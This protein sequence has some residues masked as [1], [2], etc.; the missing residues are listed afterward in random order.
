MEAPEQEILGRYR[1]I[2]RIAAGSLGTVF[3]AVD[4]R[5]GREVA[6]KLFDGGDTEGDNH[7]AWVDELRLAARLNHPNIAA[8]LDAG[9]DRL[10]RAPVLVFARALGGSLRRAIASERPF[11]EPTIL[12]LLRDVGSALAHAHALGILHRDV[13]PENILASEPLGGGPWLLTDF[14]AGR[15][16]ARGALARSLAGSLLYMAPEVLLRTATPAADQYSLGMVALELLIGALP[17]AGARSAFLQVHRRASGLHGLIARLIDPDP[18]RRFFDMHALLRALERQPLAA[19]PQLEDRAGR[20][21]MLEGDVLWRADEDNPTGVIVG[22]IGRAIGFASVDGVD[23][24]LVAAP[25]RI[26]AIAG[27]EP[28][29]VF[30]DDHPF[31]VV[32]ADLSARIA[33]LRDG[34]ELRLVSIPFGAVNGRGRLSEPM[35]AALADPHARAGALGSNVLVLGKDGA[36]ELLVCTLSP[37]KKLQLQRQTLPAPLYAL[38][39]QG[40]D[41]LATCGEQGRAVLVRL[42]RGEPVVLASAEADPDAVRPIT[43][44]RGPELAHL[45]PTLANLVHDP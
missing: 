11:D 32:A 15:F 38:F 20:R 35:L 8:C 28:S 4:A 40:G 24:A 16:L 31:T 37:E 5:S 33:W 3:A 21:Y 22:R 17:S 10:A 42:G 45:T 12:G 25:R 30:T 27:D 39:R 26:I 44:P 23:T 13:K 2:G 18:R 34:A 36:R 14:G 29:T 41:L 19:A 6:V 7:A 9:E 1:V 43:G